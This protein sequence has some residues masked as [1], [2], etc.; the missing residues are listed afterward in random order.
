MDST[1]KYE[2][3]LNR[4]GPRRRPGIDL[5]YLY[6]GFAYIQ[7]MVEHSIMAEHMGKN[8]SSL[9]GI[10]LQQ[11]PYPC[12]TED[13]F[14]IAIAR[15]FP[16]FMVLAWVY[17]A[18][19]IIK[20]IVHEKEMRLKETMRVMGLGNGVHWISWFIDSFTVMF[21]SC[22][23]LTLILVVSKHKCRCRVASQFMTNDKWL[24]NKK[25][26]LIGLELVTTAAL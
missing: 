10:S 7:D 13:R 20:S 17:S 2:D 4:R 24:L 22:V 16:L 12:Y 19:M 5:K 23:L 18:A 11:M 9:P 6:Y 15:T 8:I 3:R 1:K 25:P 21:V 14:I 26:L